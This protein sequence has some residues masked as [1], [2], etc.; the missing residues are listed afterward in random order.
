MNFPELEAFHKMI[1]AMKNDA[2]IRVVKVIAKTEEQY[3]FFIKKEREYFSEIGFKVMHFDEIHDLSTIRSNCVYFAS[4]VS[5]V[6]FITVDISDM[7]CPPSWVETFIK[8]IS[9]QGE[10]GPLKES[11]LEDAPNFSK[12][13]KYAA[14]DVNGAIA[15]TLICH[16]NRTTDLKFSPQDLKWLSAEPAEGSEKEPVAAEPE[17]EMKESE[18]TEPETTE[19]EATASEATEPEVTRTEATEPE[20]EATEPKATETEVI[21]PEATEPANMAARSQMFAAGAPNDPPVP[22][23]KNNVLDSAKDS[24]SEE[25]NERNWALLHQLIDKHN[26]CIKIIDDSYN[27]SFYPI[28]STLQEC[29]NKKVFNRQYCRIYM[30]IS[31]DYTTELYNNLYELDQMVQ[32]FHK[33][34][35][36]KKLH[37]GCPNCGSE[38]DEDLTF[39]TPGI[40]E[41]SCPKCD[42][43]RRIEV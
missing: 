4:E 43:S 15:N 14:Q 28:K 37:L 20:P 21:R 33:S 27:T 39:L 16:F 3:K 31:N 12:L 35:V 18:T 8:N 38:W 34:V 26:Q 22:T 11:E 7:A 24:L 25:E 2:P 9:L 36:R 1:S 40:H 42:M 19:P 32:D 41:V 29:V 13:N 10:N 23:K 6:L 30:D 5:N 17:T